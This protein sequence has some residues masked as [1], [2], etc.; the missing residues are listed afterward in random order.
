M[1]DAT[2]FMALR[3][4]LAAAL[5][6][7]F[8]KP[9]DLRVAKS[10]LAIGAL[11]AGGYVTQALALQGTSASRAS[12]LS[13]FTVLTV[14][15]IAGLSGQRVRP[16]VWACG[17]AALV[18]TAMLEGG[19]SLGP[20]NAGDAWAVASALFFGAQ[21]FVAERATRRLPPGSELPLMAA[22]LLSVAAIGAAAAAAL[23]A[24]DLP[25]AAAGLRRLLSDWQ[26]LLPA[27][28]GGAGG[29]GLP[30]A[31]AAEAA[32]TAQQLLY[33]AAVSTDLVLLIEIVALQV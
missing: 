15:L 32:R 8:L 30:A 24:D 27:A 17:A 26:D 5:F 9:R 13:T 2:V 10:G 20:P 23:H 33:T 22:S 12:L 4:L 18:G 21:M 11:L 25:G 16:V 19:S 1:T 3:F 29:A 14:P 31:E 6:L 28:L 7:P